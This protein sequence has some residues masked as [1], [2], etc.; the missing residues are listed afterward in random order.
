MKSKVGIG[1]V[2]VV[3]LACLITYFAASFSMQGF[4]TVG[5]N[6]TSEIDTWPLLSWVIGV[7]RIVSNAPILGFM[8][9]AFVIFKCWRTKGI[10]TGNGLLMLLAILL[11]GGAETLNNNVG[12]IAG[13]CLFCWFNAVQ[14]SSWAG[15]VAGF[16]ASW[17]RE[18]KP[19]IVF[20]YIAE[21]A[22][23]LVRFPPYADGKLGTFFSDMSYQALDP[24]LILWEN[25]AWLVVAVVAVEG[26]AVFFIKF[27]ESVRK[28][29]GN[30]R[31]ARTQGGS[32]V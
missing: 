31:S 8:L 13:F 21:I 16:N 15:K 30:G 17:A 4:L 20:F 1:G 28:Q 10:T 22:I 26:T 3:A 5:A 32:N 11:I 2:C 25:L 19:Y 27:S 9:A 24:S 6:L 14:L 23:N 7:I 18:L 29:L 12:A